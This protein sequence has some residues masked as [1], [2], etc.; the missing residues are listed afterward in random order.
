LGK[1]CTKAATRHPPRR[2]AFAGPIGPPGLRTGCDAA[3]DRDGKAPRLSTAEMKLGFS[4]KLG[5]W[6][7]GRKRAA[8]AVGVA[9]WCRANTLRV[10]QL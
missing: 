4:L 2:A 3:D 1:R 9:G 7:G 6:K 8:D 5:L 10:V